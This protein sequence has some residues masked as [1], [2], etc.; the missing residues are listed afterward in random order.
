MDGMPSGDVEEFVGDEAVRRRAK[1][2]EAR[3]NEPRS[4]QPAWCARLTLFRRP[5]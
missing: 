3:V 5:L 4:V 1:T 2:E